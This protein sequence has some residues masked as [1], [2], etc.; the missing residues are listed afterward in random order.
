[1]TGS[2]R[3]SSRWRGPTWIAVLGLALLG[4][5]GAAGEDVMPSPSIAEMLET[6]RTRVQA[7]AIYPAEAREQ[8]LEGTSRIEFQVDRTG[9]PFA[10]TTIQSSGS[11][12]L[13][14]AA[15]QGARDAA[16]LP[17]LEARIRIPIRF[18]LGTP[19]RAAAAAVVV[20]AR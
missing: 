14:D 5:P 17:Y 8:G 2:R 11:T 1:M 13:D 16:P 9:K 19:E 3:R 12:L 15:M 4:G 10:I 20:G 7:A 6:I 18:G